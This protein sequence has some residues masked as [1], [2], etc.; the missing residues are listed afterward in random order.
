MVKVMRFWNTHRVYAKGFADFPVDDV[1]LE[2]L[3]KHDD[4]NMK[5]M[6]LLKVFDYYGFTEQNFIEQ[7]KRKNLLTLSNSK[8][9]TKDILQ[10]VKEILERDND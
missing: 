10:Q 2:Q 9:E 4:L 3:Q 6:I 1:A 7:Y 5:L 8:K